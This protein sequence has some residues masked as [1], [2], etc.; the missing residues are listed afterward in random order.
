LSGIKKAND[1]SNETKKRNTF[2]ILN[3]HNKKLKHMK[4]IVK[5]GLIGGGIAAAIGAVVIIYL[6]NMPHRDIQG[7][8]ASYRLKANSLVNEFIEQPE[9]S[10]EKYLDKVIIVTG[11]VSEISE[12]QLKQKVVS[13]KTDKAGINCT[14]TEA[15]KSAADKLK[16]GDEVSIK[17]VV[18]LGAGYDEFLDITEYAILEKCDLIE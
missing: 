15:S 12:D 7:E 16:P 4:K 3:S 13:L 11:E 6:F 10:N 9:K 5:Y 17:G 8:E 14:F 2:H 1:Y 18:R